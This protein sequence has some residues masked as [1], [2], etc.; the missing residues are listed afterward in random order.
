ML[1]VSFEPSTPE[2]S[3]RG[4]LLELEAQIIAGPT[5]LGQYKIEVARNRKPLALLKLKQT[6]FVEQ[7]TEIAAEPGKADE[8]GGDKK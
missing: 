7:V 4:L 5:Q 6:N 8:T 1:S 2:S 3:I